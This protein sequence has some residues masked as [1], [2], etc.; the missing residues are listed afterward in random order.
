MS[1]PH[2]QPNAN[3]HNLSDPV[4]KTMFEISCATI[5]KEILEEIT[6]YNLSTKE[7]ELKITFNINEDTFRNFKRESLETNRIDIYLHN[8][9]GEI[10]KKI[11]L[12]DMQHLGFEIEGD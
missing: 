11:F 3:A 5:D 2:F 1:L 8:K 12:Y 7:Q 4:F 6:S 10:I 9:K